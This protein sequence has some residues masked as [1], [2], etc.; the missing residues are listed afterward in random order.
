MSY[1][2]GESYLT[3]NGGKVEIVGVDFLDNLP[4][5]IGQNLEVIAYRFVGGSGEIYIRIAASVD[6]RPLNEV[7]VG[8]K[9][10]HLNEA[11]V[12]DMDREVTYVSED[13]VVYRVSGPN[14]RAREH[15]TR[16][17]AFSREFEIG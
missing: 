6:F 7:R 12:D 8:D 11:G 13:V 16:M 3:K 15:A 9:I 10:R 17:D 1:I 5:S 14:I 2:R 4:G